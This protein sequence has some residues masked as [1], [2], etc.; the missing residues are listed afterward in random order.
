MFPPFDTCIFMFICLKQKLMK[1]YHT[2]SL[3]VEIKIMGH[4]RCS[5][6]K[7][8]L[9]SRSITLWRHCMQQLGKVSTARFDPQAYGRYANEPTVTSV[10]PFPLFFVSRTFYSVPVPLFLAIFLWSFCPFIGENSFFVS[11]S[12]QCRNELTASVVIHGM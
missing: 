4:L 11:R 7:P 5:L 12:C 1:G 2:R 9:F 8:S 6:T 3:V 10:S